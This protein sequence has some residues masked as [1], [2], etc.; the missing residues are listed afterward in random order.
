MVPGF[1]VERVVVRRGFDGRTF[2]AQARAGA[3]PSPG[4][5]PP[6]VV[7]TAQPTLRS[8]S[9]VFFGL[10][11]WRTSD[12]GRTWDGPVDHSETLGRRPEPDGVTVAV[13]DMTPGW[14]AASGKLLSTGHT[15]R[16]RDDSGPM[17]NRRREV[18]YSVYEPAGRTWSPWATVALPDRPEF[19][20]AGAGSAQRYDLA[21]GTIL[22]PIYFKRPSDDARACMSATVLRCAFDGRRLRYLEHGTELSVAE[23]RG[24]GEPSITRFGGRFLLTLRN[25]VRGYVAAGGTD[26]LRFGPPQPWCFDDGTEL[27]NYNTQQHWVT[28]GEGL[29]LVY[30]RRGLNNDHV[31]RHRAPLMMA[32]VDPQRLVVLRD[33][34]CE[35]VPN[36]GA[37]LGNF[38]VCDP[39]PDETWVVVA[40]WMQPVGCEKYGSDNTIWVAR[41]I[42]DRPAAG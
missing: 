3:I 15:V 17:V 33:T 7:L 26:G 13:C 27:G 4:G 11:E 30:T 10:S 42:W 8:G 34:E 1:R 36:R 12:L 9:D 22:L 41:I 16:Y 2:W 25:D 24:L 28:H 6:T 38:A 5:R 23:P 31:F 20:S 37:R 32:R 40:E 14:H 39:S 18:A 29:F 19:L 35:L 21:D